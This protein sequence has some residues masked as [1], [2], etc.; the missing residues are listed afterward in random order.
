MRWASVPVRGRTMFSKRVVSWTMLLPDVS[1][2]HNETK[3]VTAQARRFSGSNT[4]MSAWIS[5]VPQFIYT[6]LC[7]SFANASYYPGL[8][9][10]TFAQTSQVIRLITIIAHLVAGKVVE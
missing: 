10:C 4:L 8:V 2:N 1:T 6:H 9:V 7:R 3:S 5:S